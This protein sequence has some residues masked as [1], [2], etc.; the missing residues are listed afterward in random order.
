MFIPI[1]VIT[2]PVEENRFIDVWSC[3]SLTAA[4]ATAHPLSGACGSLE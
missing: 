1:I 3:S 2:L 4:A